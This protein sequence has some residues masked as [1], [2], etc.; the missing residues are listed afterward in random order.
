MQTTLRPSLA[1][2]GPHSRTVATASLHAARLLPQA[3]RVQVCSAAAACRLPLP[4]PAG[5]CLS[6]RHSPAAL[7]PLV[8]PGLL[9]LQ[10]SV[11]L[12]RRPLQQQQR[13]QQPATV[14]AAAGGAAVAAA[15]AAQP[16]GKGGAL[17]ITSYVFLW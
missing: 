6:V 12:R 14:A 3:A 17:K 4:L 16:S 8:Q 7:S 1:S 10:H 15:A 5:L 2:A 13:R 9:P 11:A